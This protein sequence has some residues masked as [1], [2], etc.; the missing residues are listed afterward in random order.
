MT[1]LPMFESTVV[2]VLLNIFYSSLIFL[3]LFISF[4]KKKNLQNLF[5]SYMCI[6]HYTFFQTLQKKIPFTHFIICEDK[7][8]SYYNLQ[9]GLVDASVYAGVMNVLDEYAYECL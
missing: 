9:S 6:S 3:V 5:N 2:L 1:F 7:S 4:F 8:N